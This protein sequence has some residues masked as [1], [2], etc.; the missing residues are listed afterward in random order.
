MGSDPKTC[1]IDP[2]LKVFGISGLHII[3]T[4][5]FPTQVSGHPA[6]PVVAIAE[7]VANMIKS[8]KYV[9]G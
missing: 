7:K 9:W 6:A 5:I 4:S 1:I 8:D 3:D 2:K